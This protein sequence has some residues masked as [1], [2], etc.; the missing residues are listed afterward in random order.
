MNEPR[1]LIR[2][3]LARYTGQFVTYSNGKFY[4]REKRRAKSITKQQ[5]LNLLQEETVNYRTTSEVKVSDLEFIELSKVEHEEVIQIAGQLTDSGL[6]MAI[7]PIIIANE[8]SRTL[9]L[10]YEPL[11]DVRQIQKSKINDFDSNDS[12]RFIVTKSNQ[13][14]A[15]AK[16]LS[17]LE[18]RYR[19][20]IRVAEFDKE[21]AQKQLTKVLTYALS[22]EHDNTEDGTSEG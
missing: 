5:M 11:N 20:D 19:K 17:N 14:K 2:I 4:A 12:R 9:R 18:A 3:K 10:E 6:V 8:T 7:K 15:E 21:H 22:H 1:Y 13:A 16:I